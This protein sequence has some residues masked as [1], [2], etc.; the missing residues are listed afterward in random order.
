MFTHRLNIKGGSREKRVSVFDKHSSDKSRKSLES[1][2]KQKED[3]EE[4]LT[5]YKQN[6]EE[7]E[8]QLHYKREKVR[9]I[10][11]KILEKTKDLVEVDQEILGSFE[12][13]RKARQLMRQ[14]EMNIWDMERE[15]EETQEEYT[16]TEKTP[17]FDKPISIP[18][19]RLEEIGVKP[20]KVPARAILQGCSSKIDPDN[21]Q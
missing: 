13:I 15:L 14:N 20:H 1:L 21:P 19:W 2:M 18:M 8:K 12:D 4:T 9:E 17:V 10:N 3:K 6:N 5:K 11:L 7:I 16:R